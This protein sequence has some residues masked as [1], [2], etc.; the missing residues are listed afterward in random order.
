MGVTLRVI[1]INLM[2]VTFTVLVSLVG[3]QTVGVCSPG[4]DIDDDLTDF[5]APDFTLNDM[6][7]NKVSLGD[8]KGNVI[9]ITFWATWCETCREEIKHLNALVERF[10]G[11]KFVVLAISTDLFE[12]T[13]LR[14]LKKNPAH[15]IVLH[16]SDSKVARAYKAYSLP[17][18]FIID[19]RGRIVERIMGPHNKMSPDFLRKIE[20]LF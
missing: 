20:R 14:F 12:E 15:Y 6:K 3:Y 16:D 7:G 11:K 10:R 18:A 9:Y 4:F 13:I 2:V 1:L 5:P 8:L 17:A 19:K